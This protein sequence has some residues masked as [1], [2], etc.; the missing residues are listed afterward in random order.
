M[1][2]NLKTSAR[3]PTLASSQMATMYKHKKNANSA[4][5]ERKHAIKCE[6]ARHRSITLCILHGLVPVISG[7]RPGCQR[8]MIH[9]DSAVDK[10][11]CWCRA[12][13]FRSKFGDVLKTLILTLAFVSKSKHC[14]SV[15]EPLQKWRL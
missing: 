6:M 14:P 3:F 10:H 7:H 9:T 11:Q 15:C 5:G 1:R 13:T 12:R 4:L 2:G 8:M